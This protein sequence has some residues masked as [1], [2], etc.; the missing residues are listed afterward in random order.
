LALRNAVASIVDR[1]IAWIEHDRQRKINGTMPPEVS[2]E[3]L[4]QSP[5]D[6]TYSS[7]PNRPPSTSGGS[8][9]NTPTH[10]S[11]STGSEAPNAAIPPRSN[12][13]NDS[14]PEASSYPPLPYNETA[15]H[16]S[17]NLS[18]AT[19]DPYIYSQAA[20]VQVPAH[21]AQAQAQAQ[22]QQST[23]TPIGDH[24]PL[25]TF[26]AQ[27][28]ALQQP[29]P[30][31]MWRQGTPGGNTWQDWTAAVV[32][33]QDRYS[34]NALMSLGAG[35]RPSSGVND[36]TP[37]TPGMGMGVGNMAGANVPTSANNSQ[38]P[39]LLF[40]EGTGMGGA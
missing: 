34:A 17:N 1:T 38:W 7:L 16:D 15:P 33:N 19:E 35:A 8:L 18:Y 11:L 28:T 30:D 29:S 22:V 25:S 3:L 40:H 5:Q 31:M 24:N 26:A 39:L 23:Q 10:P 6:Q 14:A 12:Y 20:Q 27:A 13:Y 37:N 32:D 21:Q 4:R 2:Q 9:Q 36:G